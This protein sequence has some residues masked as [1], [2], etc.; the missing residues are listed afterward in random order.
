MD[1]VKLIAIL[2]IGLL[3]NG[4]SD[5]PSAKSAEEEIAEII[6]NDNRDIRDGIPASVYPEAHYA[7]LFIDAEHIEIS[8]SGQ[9]SEELSG[10]RHSSYS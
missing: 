2:C 10:Q 4:C 3:I 8:D 6:A 5:K 7:K 9:P 1:S